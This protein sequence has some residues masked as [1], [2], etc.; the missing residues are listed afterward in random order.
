M[1]QGRLVALD[2]IEALRRRAR[3]RL[4]LHLASPADPNRF[5]QLPGVVEA[6]AVDTTICLVIEGSVDAVIKAAAHEEVLRVVSHD[7]DLEDVF[8]AYYRD[9][10]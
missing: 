10:P 3:Q 2:H 5:T 4:D 6:D 9:Q 7:A 8:L 1:K